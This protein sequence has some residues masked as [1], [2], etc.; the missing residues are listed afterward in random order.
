VPQT[1]VTPEY[2]TTNCIENVGVRP[3]NVVDFM[4][5]DNLLNHAAPL[6]DALAAAAWRL[7]N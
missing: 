7:L 1:V 3:D 4:T 2:P 5:Q 6:G